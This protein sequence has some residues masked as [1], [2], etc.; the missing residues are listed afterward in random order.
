MNAR[1]SHKI[2]YSAFKMKI[3]L[4][5]NNKQGKTEGDICY[6]SELGIVLGSL[7]NVLSQM[8]D[9]ALE[10]GYIVS[11][12]Y[13]TSYDILDPLHNPEELVLI[14]SQRWHVPEAL[15]SY[16]PA[17]EPSDSMLDGETF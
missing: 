15:A 8:I 5:L 3:E 10:D 12:P 11:H 14:I 1:L 9:D 4:E 16:L 17:I 13:P 6:D 2:Y 7:A